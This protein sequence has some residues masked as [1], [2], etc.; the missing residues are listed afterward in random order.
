MLQKDK[1][2]SGLIL[3]NSNVLQDYTRWHLPKEATV[4]LGKGLSAVNNL[5]CISKENT[6]EIRIEDIIL[7]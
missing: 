1:N 6:C 3:P 5:T 7:S 4:R 2:T